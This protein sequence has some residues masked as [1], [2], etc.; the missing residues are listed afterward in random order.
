MGELLIPIETERRQTSRSRL[1]SLSPLPRRMRATISPL[2]FLLALASLLLHFVGSDRYGFFRDELYYI[3]C[4][5]HLALGY[6]DQPPLIGLIARLSSLA[7]GT[8]LSAFRFFP[9]L[10]GACLVLLTGGM[11][12]ELGG[13]VSP[14]RLRV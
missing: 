5:N 9:A 3:A 12:R 2:V 1:R 7:L 4:G 13:G 8:T 6:V 14:K 11:T 10:A